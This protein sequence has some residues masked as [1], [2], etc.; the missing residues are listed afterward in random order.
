MDAATCDIEA[1]ATA[2]L[3]ASCC[4]ARRGSGGP[5]R[6]RRWPGSDGPFLARAQ[7]FPCFNCALRSRLRLRRG[8]DGLLRA[9]SPIEGR[10]PVI[11]RFRR[12]LSF[13]K[14]SAL[15]F[16]GVLQRLGA[17]GPLAVSAMGLC[18]S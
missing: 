13:L 15:Q 7:Y 14:L 16:Q 5:L 3:M 10:R 12:F 8:L 11:R 4:R 9:L 17:A 6:G 2:P 18:P 1:G